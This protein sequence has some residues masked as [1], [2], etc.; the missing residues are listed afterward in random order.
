VRRAQVGER[1]AEQAVAADLSEAAEADAGGVLV[2][3]AFGQRA[4]ERFG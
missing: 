2:A 1:D 4:V 3:R